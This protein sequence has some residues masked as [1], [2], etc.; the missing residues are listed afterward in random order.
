MKRLIMT[1]IAFTLVAFT[2]NA[3][4]ERKT[5]HSKHQRHD[6]MKQL[7]LSEDQKKQ[8]GTIK[9]EYRL[10]MQELNKNESIT[11][12]ESRDRKETMRKEQKSRVLGMLTTAQKQQ[13]EQLKQDKKARKEAHFTKKLDKMKTNL[14]LSDDQLAKMK[15]G[16]ES[17]KSRVKSIKENQVI[18]RVQRKEQLMALKNERKAQMDNILTAEQKEKLKEMKKKHH[19]KDR[20]K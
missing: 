13:L 10:K 16:R 19:N 6:A 15:A 17:M 5:K 2:A 8:A 18:D 20:V 1:A 12:K 14:Q 7:N 9:Q 11:V 4:L 3:Q